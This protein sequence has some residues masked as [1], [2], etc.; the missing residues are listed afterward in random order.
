MTVKKFC[1][2]TALCLFTTNLYQL[3]KVIH[4]CYVEMLKRY[5]K[6]LCENDFNFL[7]AT[8]DSAHAH[9]SLCCNTHSLYRIWLHITFFFLIDKGNAKEGY[10]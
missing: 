5:V 10:T 3:G 9:K 7:Q 8:Y 4:A 6:T 2:L 1:E